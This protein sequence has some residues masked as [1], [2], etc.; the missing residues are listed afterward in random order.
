MKKRLL[1]FA[2]LCALA[3]ARLSA[4]SGATE[5]VTFRFVAGDNMFYSPF[6]GNA[7]NL[8]N[9]E[10]FIEK[11]R[12]VI[13]SGKVPIHVNGY[14]A[15]VGNVEQRLARAKI[16]SN[17]VKSQ[18]IVDNGMKEGYFRTKNSS[19]PLG[20]LQNV[21]VVSITVPKE[22]PAPA[23]K[24][25]PE[26]K[27][28]PAPTPKP[29]PA[30][31]TTPAQKPAAATTTANAQ[32]TPATE[33]AATVPV[34]AQPQVQQQPEEVDVVVWEVD[35]FVEP[36]EPAQFVVRGMLRTNLLYWLGGLPNFGMELRTS[37]TFSVIV[38]AGMAPWQSVSWQH[39]WAGW[40]LSPEARFYL[41]ANKR[42]FTGIV[43]VVGDY[44]LKP[45]QTGRRGNVLVGGL[46]VGYKAFLSNTFDMDFSLGAGY[47]RLKYN[48][49]KTENGQQVVTATNVVKKG[50]WPIQAGVSLIWKL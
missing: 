8:K 17:R 3:V 30:P 6:E 39:N 11:N 48:V 33:A 12:E 28:A 42:W 19:Y 26:A 7:E 14:C 15:T 41:G 40:F 34:K 10:A 50:I 35:T 37:P 2:M 5:Q 13:V 25:T 4:Q 16:M 31:V 32:P 20:K 36:V 49:Y 46:S 38:N 21:V 9:L 24:P 44:N 29:T 22:A 23:P 43:G 18:L 45:D 1:F 27:P 47:G